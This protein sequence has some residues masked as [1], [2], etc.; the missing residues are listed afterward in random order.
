MQNSTPA[1]ANGSDPQ[2]AAPRLPSSQNITVRAA[3]E[4]GDRNTSTLI[5]A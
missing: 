4:F 1:A 5:T 2:V 3:S